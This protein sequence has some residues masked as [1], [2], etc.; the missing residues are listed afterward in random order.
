[1]NHLYIIEQ[2]TN[3]SN[4]HIY[5]NETLI[6]YNCCILKHMIMYYNKVYHAMIDGPKILILH[7]DLFSPEALLHSADSS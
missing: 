3:I 7:D 2:P 5:L 4:S 1:M 6:K